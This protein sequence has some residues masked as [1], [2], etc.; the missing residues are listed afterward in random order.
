MNA[1]T[2]EQRALA[3]LEATMDE[4]E[5]GPYRLRFQIRNRSRRREL[6]N[7]YLKHRDELLGFLSRHPAPSRFESLS[8]AIV[9]F[10][11]EMARQ[12][13]LNAN[14]HWAFSNGVLAA[15]KERL[16]IAR[17]FQLVEQAEAADRM[18]EAA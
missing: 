1:L 17:Y 18:R 12:R 9:W 16:V 10:R 8:E 14:G 5:A 15:C 3:K 4:R 6:V 13:M 2:A 7:H 11:K